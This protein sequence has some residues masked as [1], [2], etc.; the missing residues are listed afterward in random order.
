L[1]S[2]VHAGER[3]PIQAQALCLLRFANQEHA[4]S[5]PCILR[6]VTCMSANRFTRAARPLGRS[7]A[8]FSNNP[9][10]AARQ[11]FTT[12]SARRAAAGNNPGHR[13]A[14]VWSL[15]GVFGVAA[16]AGLLGWGVAEVR[17]RGFPGAVLLDGAFP[18]ARY[19]SVRGMEQVCCLSDMR[20]D[21][22]GCQWT[23]NSN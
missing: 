18:A 19:A 17:H 5:A 23:R 9:C 12:T 1:R 22:A 6:L 13:A 11:R 10:S 14:S 16:A 3:E 2:Q 4:K 21:S 20:H 7:L 8:T 15:P